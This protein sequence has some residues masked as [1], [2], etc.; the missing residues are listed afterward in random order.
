MN[1]YGVLMLIVLFIGATAYGLYRLRLHRKRQHLARIDTLSL[2]RTEETILSTL[3]HYR[4]LSF[5]EQEKVRRLVLR[6]VHTKTFEGIGIEVTEEMTFI[7]AFYACLLL[8][9][10]K[11]PLPYPEITTILIYPDAIVYEQQ[12]ND[13]GI[14]T[15]E[16]SEIDGQAADDT[17]IITWDAAFEEATLQQEANL[18]LH[19]F[20]HVIDAMDGEIDGI[21]PL[22]KTEAEAW[23]KTFDPIFDELDRRVHSTEDLGTYDFFG[24]DAATDEAELFAV[25]TERFFGVP[26]EFAET[27]PDLYECFRKFYGFDAARTFTPE[28]QSATRIC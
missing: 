28:G 7:I 20:A 14:V 10:K 1:Y 16:V 18:I 12:R 2:S 23:M 26:K 17:V 5:A 3:P 25:A 22:E 27:F 8:L 9:H 21:P 6:F 13:G 4:N 15:D 24:E 19:E 11:A